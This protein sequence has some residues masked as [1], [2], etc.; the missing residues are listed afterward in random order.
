MITISAPS[1]VQNS[2]VLFE[3]TAV[4]RQLITSQEKG[5]PEGFEGLTSYYVY[6]NEM[7]NVWFL[8]NTDVF[9]PLLAENGLLRRA[10]QNLWSAYRYSQEY[11]AF[12]LGSYSK[13]EFREVAKTYAEPFD[14]SIDD[15]MLKYAAALLPNV[16]GESLD[17]SDFSTML[18][19]DH[20]RV[21]DVC[22]LTKGKTYEIEGK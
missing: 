12:L 1:M 14:D 9:L 11:T 8:S 15:M 20:K 10:V 17:S 4:S 3:G 16:V 7:G 18:N 22:A 19:V 2:G 21:S 13:E 5:E 6:S